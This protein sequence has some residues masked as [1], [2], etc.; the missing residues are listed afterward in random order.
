MICDCG[1]VL[2]HL[3]PVCTPLARPTCNVEEAVDAV[4]DCSVV[5][6]DCFVTPVRRLI[7]DRSE[8]YEIVRAVLATVT[9]PVE[10]R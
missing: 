3:C 4:M 9:P 8:A 5:S 10:E 2:T 6:F 7:S 1:E